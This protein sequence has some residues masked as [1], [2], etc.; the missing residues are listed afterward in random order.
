MLNEVDA[1]GNSLLRVVHEPAERRR[2]LLV[3]KRLEG[4]LW[5]LR[6][7]SFVRQLHRRWRSLRLLRVHLLIR[8]LDGTVGQRKLTSGFFD[9]RHVRLCLG[10]QRQAGLRRLGNTPRSGIVRLERLRPIATKGLQ[11][12]CIVACAAFV[13]LL[14]VVRIHDA[15]VRGGAGKQLHRADGTFR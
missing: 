12:L 8:L 6:R 1:G 5:R 3:A 11:L 9:L 7:A 13:I 10:R 15:H 14:R 2:R 4:V